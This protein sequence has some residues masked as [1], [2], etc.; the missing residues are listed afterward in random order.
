MEKKTELVN[1]EQAEKNKAK[2]TEQIDWEKI[3]LRFGI[4]VSF[5]T[6]IGFL[7]SLSFFIWNF[8]SEVV[9][10][11]EKHGIL[12]GRIEVLMQER[13]NNSVKCE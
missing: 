1:L 9:S 6:I 8:H 4:I 2:S 12:E 3:G 11:S 5:F 10:L 7:I 13:A